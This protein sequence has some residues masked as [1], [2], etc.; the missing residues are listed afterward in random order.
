MACVWVGWLLL[1]IKKHSAVT[2]AI[3]IM[4]HSAVRGLLAEARFVLQAKILRTRPSRFPSLR[5]LHLRPGWR[6]WNLRI[7]KIV[8]ASHMVVAIYGE[9]KFPVISIPVFCNRDST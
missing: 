8:K 6:R 7:F 2:R 9:G 5:E 3:W 1:N 4:G